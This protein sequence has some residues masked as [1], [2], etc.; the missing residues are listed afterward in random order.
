MLGEK[1]RE[2]RK[3]LG[4]NQKMVADEWGV[5]IAMVSL[6]ERDCYKTIPGRDILQQIAN[7][8]DLG[9]G[10]VYTLLSSGL[11]TTAPQASTRHQRKPRSVI[12]GD[13]VVDGS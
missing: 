4:L 8:V 7:F 6:L 12:D 1:I 3:L 9:N 11:S 5:S 13:A 2:R 10:T